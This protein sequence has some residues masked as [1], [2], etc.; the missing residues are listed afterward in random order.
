MPPRYTNSRKSSILPRFY[1]TVMPI[2]P[3]VARP[4]AQP[5]AQPELFIATQR[6]AEPCDCLVLAIDTSLDIHGAVYEFDQASGGTITRLIA[7]GEVTGKRGQVVSLVSPQADTQCLVK[8]V[9]LGD[10]LTR[11]TAFEMA[12]LAIRQCCDR[13][14]QRVVLAISQWFDAQD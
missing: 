8:L 9:G 7:A 5:I 2:S 6:A 11:G 13:P 4:V 12:S 14:R 10:S 1:R 3:S